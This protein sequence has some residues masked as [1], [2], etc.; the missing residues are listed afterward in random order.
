LLQSLKLAKNNLNRKFK[1]RIADFAETVEDA[2]A[3]RN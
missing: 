1:Q 2:Y 3:K